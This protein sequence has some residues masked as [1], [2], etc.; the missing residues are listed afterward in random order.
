MGGWKVPAGTEAGLR[1]VLKLEYYFA[2][3]EN[4][5]LNPLA[6]NCLRKFDIYDNLSWGVRT[7]DGADQMASEWKY[8]LVR[9]LA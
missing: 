9:R 2:D 6:I 5:T 1:G 8:I 7:L 3:W 4:G